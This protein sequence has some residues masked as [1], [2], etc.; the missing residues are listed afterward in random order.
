MTTVRVRYAPSPT[1]SP[2]I[3]NIRTAVFDWLFARHSGGK[4]ILRIEDTDKNR[5]VAG[6]I[7]EQL[8]ALSW[9]GLDVDEGYGVGG[10]FGPYLQSE[11]LDIYAKCANTLIEG[12]K[13]YRAYDTAEDLARMREEQ[14]KRG[15]PPGYNRRHRYLTLDE[16]AE[17]ES[18]PNRASTVRFA[19]P[20]EGKTTLHDAVY[21]DVAVDNRLLED[22]VLL[23]SDGFPTYHFASI[24]DDHLMEITHVLRGEEWIPS[25]PIHILLYQAFGWEPPQFVHL[26]V[27]MG[28]DKKKFGKRNGAL[29]ALEYAKEGYLAE[30]MF[31]F[32]ALQGWSAKEER[33]LYS[34][35]ELVER[36]NLEGLIN[37]SPISDPEKLLWYNGQYIRAMPAVELAVRC[38]PFLRSASLVGAAADDV[39]LEY[40]AEVIALEQQRIKTLAESPSL[41]GFFLVDD[42]DIAYDQKAT[43]K[44]FSH[45]GV[46]NRLTA[47]S[48]R[49]SSLSDFTADECETAVRAVAEQ[50][51]VKTGDVIHPIRVAIS[52]RT[53][54][55]GLFET[56]SVLGQ[57][58]VIARINHALTLVTE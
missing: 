14:Q 45:A 49:L 16:R 39:H 7:D 29:A 28:P 4:F 23:K 44:W 2:H 15:L 30:A 25:A 40:I 6:G 22:V 58:R 1:G 37:H 24:V 51:Q 35:Q 41:A 17:Y 12:G 50:F 56:M 19:V 31:N 5:E 32:L 43:D 11:R 57:D 47:V 48:T 54:G 53:T 26:P 18:D 55:P 42:T 20:L 34:R 21:G 10:D 36:F 8:A 9:L 33:D 27:M 52:G 38:L 46:R 3:G 13:A